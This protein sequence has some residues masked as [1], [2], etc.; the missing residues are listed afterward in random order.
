MKRYTIGLITLL[1]IVGCSKPEPINYETT[2][3]KRDGVYYTKDTNKPYSGPVFSLWEN[4][5]KS[6]EGTFNDGKRVGLW[7]S[8]LQ[9]GK[10]SF[11]LIY[12]DGNPWDGLK[13]WYYTSSGRKSSVKTYEDGKVIYE[14]CWNIYGYETY[15]N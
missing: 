7:T 9:N 10:E 14:E 2:L 6:S 1:L 3:V 13:L 5:Q 11:D 12:K 8:W 15:C 4:G